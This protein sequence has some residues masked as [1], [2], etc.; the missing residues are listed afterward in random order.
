MKASTI[1]KFVLVVASLATACTGL[2]VY[3]ALNQSN[4][5]APSA[6]ASSVHRVTY[7]VDGSAPTVSLTYTNE[8]GGGEQRMVYRD[9]QYDGQPKP[10]ALE[11][12]RPSGTSL[13]IAAQMQDDR[14]RSVHVAIF[15][16]GMK[17]QDASSDAPYGIATASAL[18]P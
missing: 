15:V 1:V 8:S 9:R 11:M 6:S 14:Y 17:V 5:G 4:S 3:V 10:W 7:L 18:V 2:V 12:H 13:Y 16:D